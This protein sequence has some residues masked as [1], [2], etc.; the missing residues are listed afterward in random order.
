MTG[1]VWFISESHR[2][3]YSGH[4]L[5]VGWR[6]AISRMASVPIYHIKSGIYLCPWNTVKVIKHTAPA[7]I[8]INYHAS[9]FTK[10]WATSLLFL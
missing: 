5:G 7:N 8:V 10:S 2:A 6:A 9:V 1:V 4:V 3:L